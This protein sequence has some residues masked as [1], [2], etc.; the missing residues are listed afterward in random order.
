MD[1]ANLCENSHTITDCFG[2]EYRVLKM[3][4]SGFCLYHSLSYCLTGNDE[5]YVG[6][7]DDCLTVFQN[8]PELFRFRTNFGSYCDSS[9][10]VDDYALYMQQ[11][12][13]LV[14]ADHSVDSHA[15]G[16]EGHIAA[17]ALLYDITVFTYNT[18]N[19]SWYVFNESSRCG[20]ICLLNLPNHFDVLHGINGPPAIPLGAH[21]LG[22][23]RHNFN[24]SDDA[25]KSLQHNCLFQY[26]F[27]FPQEY[28]G[29]QILNNPV[30][31]YNE[32]CTSSNVLVVN[33]GNNSYLCDYDQ[34]NYTAKNPRSLSMHKIRCHSIKTA[35]TK[36]IPLR[37]QECVRNNTLVAYNESCTVDD[38]A[39]DNYSND[40]Y[41]CDYD[42]CNYRYRTVQTLS[43]H[44]LRCHGIK[45][46]SNK[47]NTSCGQEGTSGVLDVMYTT[48]GDNS[49]V[50]NDSNGKCTQKRSYTCEY[51]CDF[52][53]CR[54]IGKNSRGLQ[55]HK[56]KCHAVT[57]MLKARTLYK[58]RK[59]LQTTN[60]AENDVEVTVCV[61]S[62]SNCV[63][64]VA[65]NDTANKSYDGDSFVSIDSN[66]ISRS[67][68]VA[69]KRTVSFRDS[70]SGSQSPNKAQR[71]SDINDH[72]LQQKKKTGFTDKPKQ[73]TKS[74]PCVELNVEPDNAS[75]SSVISTDS[76]L[77]RSARIFSRKRSC[78]E[79]RPHNDTA[80]NNKSTMINAVD[81]N[82]RHTQKI[83]LKKSF[84]QL[85]AECERN[86]TPTTVPQ[87]SDPLYDKL[88]AYHDNLLRSVS[89]TTTEKISAEI[90]DV[91]ENVSLIDTSERRYLWSVNDEERLNELNRTCKLLQPRTQWTWGAPDD[92]EQGQYNDK[93]MQLCV[94]KECEWKIIECRN[95]DSTGIL[96]GDQIDSEICYDC[97]KLYRVNEKERKKRE[98]AWNKVKPI[99]KDFPKA[100]DGKDLERLSPGEKAVISP[101][102]PVVTIKKN[103][104]AD[105]RLRL[106]CISLLQDP[107]PTWVKTLPRTSLASRF[108]IIER[109]VKQCEKY[110]VANA[111]RVRQWL[112][113][114]FLHHKDFIRMRQQNQLAI[115]EAA[116][117]ALEANKEL[118]E[119][120][121]GLAEHAESETRQI[122]EAVEREDDGITDATAESGF[123]ETHV[124]TFDRYPELYLKTKD[125][126]KIRK[127]GKLEIITDNTVRKPTYSSSASVAFP[128]LYS[129]GE[130]SPLDF[131]DY[132]LGRYLLKKQ[133]L[134][135]HK[136]DDGRLQ[137]T[138]ADDDIHMAHQYSRLSEQTVRANVGYYLS[139]HPSV[140]HVP[141][142]N[143]ITAFRD[144]VD[145]DSGLL[146]SHL[147]DLTTVMS[148]LP[149][150]RQKWFQERLAISQ[151]SCDSGSP[152]VFVTINLD[153]RASPDVR[154]LIYRLEHGKDMDRDEPFIKDTSEFT[155]LINKYAPFVAIYLYRK[156]EILMDGF[157]TK[158]CGI[159][160]MEVNDWTHKDVTDSG[161]YWGR[162]EFTAVSYTHLTLPTILRV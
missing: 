55:I 83:H 1:C 147:P 49:Q 110:I 16:D 8:I 58:E 43:L 100:A 60:I 134:Y 132:K 34:C 15:Y 79:N 30:V 48:S 14:Q 156:V 80:K 12:I 6:I 161:W 57:D 78:E 47:N 141:L 130:M 123:S 10:T 93:R 135:A 157:F 89:N 28:S 158:I 152:N 86:F 39:V 108:M 97:L 71:V 65:G 23:N 38:V 153:P 40:L 137:W 27:R 82:N 144:G 7:I 95:C 9:L 105:K 21:T 18:Q 63:G 33:S 138:Y 26:A 54:Y 25:W 126:L 160:K 5:Q 29:V 42:Q 94:T 120:D 24:T 70:Q 122:E 139:A 111:D 50:R 155:G 45:T 67:E 2:I 88:K 106:E 145:K 77:R 104:Y 119:V 81:I 19:K 142:S 37:K 96:V 92:T 103:H 85:I 20:Y 51:M 101:V 136:M 31:I 162:V 74:H 3:R 159:P 46:V 56:T 32:T 149:N 13:E 127:E 44:K 125:V 113:Y 91:V 109:R 22:V 41:L 131:G 52:E 53:Q 107:V 146:D 35:S 17:I 84:S 121:R 4:G 118:A 73:R 140:A 154:R 76:G 61:E 129:H 148:Q 64:T 124:F 128:H 87:Q 62:S 143:I 112:R 59:Q 116:L 99:S 66:S 102:H 68:R 151:I 69:K 114:L 36:N 98:E 75:V 11:A 72:Q 90:L 117:D 115:D 133:S 150:S